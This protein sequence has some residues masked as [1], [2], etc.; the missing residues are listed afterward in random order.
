[1]T[2]AEQFPGG[3]PGHTIRPRARSR[4]GS[5]STSMATTLP[6]TTMKPMTEPGPA[7][8]SDD[9]SGSAVDEGGPNE[10]REPGVG[11]RLGCHG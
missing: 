10:R 5:A 11:D 8:R 7:V 3:H 2:V 9:G 6:F 4:A 1:M